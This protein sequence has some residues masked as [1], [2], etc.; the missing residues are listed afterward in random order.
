MTD[1]L[2]TMISKSHP[3]I[4]RNQTSV[5]NFTDTTKRN[6]NNLS[7]RQRHQQNQTDKVTLDIVHTDSYGIKGDSDWHGNCH[8]ATDKNCPEGYHWKTT[9]NN[10]YSGYWWSNSNA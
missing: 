1:I 10:E 6:T 7:N 2:Y 4:K 3:T 5:V 8:R 9:I